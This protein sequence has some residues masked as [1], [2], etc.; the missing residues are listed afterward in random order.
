M[1]REVGIEPTY[2]VLFPLNA[3][4]NFITSSMTEVKELVQVH[5]VFG[6]LFCH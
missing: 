5:L 6:R 4:K 3:E 2:A 1:E